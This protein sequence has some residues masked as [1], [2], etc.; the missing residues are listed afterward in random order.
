MRF[1]LQGQMQAW[2]AR[3]W[4]ASC[5]VTSILQHPHSA[6]SP[7]LPTPAGPASG[8][9]PCVLTVSGREN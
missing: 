9:A 7:V 3:V 4:L 2:R 1:K 5:R 8:P 6:L